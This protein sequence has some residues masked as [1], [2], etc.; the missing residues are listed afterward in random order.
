MWIQTRD[1]FIPEHDGYALRMVNGTT[2]V[3]TTLVGKVGETGCFGDG[4]LGTEARMGISHCVKIHPATGDLY[5]CDAGCGAIRKLDR[6]TG[7][8]TTV[9]GILG[10]PGSSGNGGSALSAKLAFPVDIEFDAETNDMYIAE[11][12]I[13]SSAR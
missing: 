3:L 8:V 6:S 10:E 12:E 1:V 5:F 13:M 11:F 2:G 9:V 4:V 7:I